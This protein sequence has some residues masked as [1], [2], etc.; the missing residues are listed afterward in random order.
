MR[1][2]ASLKRLIRNVGEDNFQMYGLR[3]E[4]TQSTQRLRCQINGHD[5]LASADTSA[6]VPLVSPPDAA[7]YC[8]DPKRMR[9]ESQKIRLAD[10]SLAR[11]TQSFDARLTI[12]TKTVQTRFYTLVGLTAPAL[13]AELLFGLNIFA[14]HAEDFIEVN[15]AASPY[16]LKGGKWVSKAENKLLRFGRRNQ[17]PVQVLPTLYELVPTDPDF[18]EK[19]CLVMAKEDQRR[20]DARQMIA[21]QTGGWRQASED[22]EKMAVDGFEAEKIRK[23]TAFERHRST[24]TR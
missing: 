6:P 13:S 18:S 12:G 20:I 10:N 4:S 7:K 14:E 3:S 17:A 2:S 24:V 11:I 9:R 22:A 23:R 21:S 19:L 15:C 16:D 1:P 8:P 5:V